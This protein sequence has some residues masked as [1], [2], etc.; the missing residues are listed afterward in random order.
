VDTDVGEEGA[1]MTAVATNDKRVRSNNGKAFS[2]IESRKV[3]SRTRDDD[4]IIER[5]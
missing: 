1:A 5:L 3:R 4:V 2:M